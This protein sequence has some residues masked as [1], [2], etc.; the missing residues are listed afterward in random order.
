VCH[1]RLRH[2]SRDFLRRR[3]RRATVAA[4]RGSGWQRDGMGKGTGG[5]DRDVKIRIEHVLRDPRERRLSRPRERRLSR[6][7]WRRTHRTPARQCSAALLGVLGPCVRACCV[8]ACCVQGLCA[9]SGMQRGSN[10]V[11]GRVW[12]GGLQL[13]S[14]NPIAMSCLTTAASLSAS[15]CTDQWPP[16]SNETLVRFTAI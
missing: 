8:C 12:Q 7:C 4:V 16:A 2:K 3:R 15:P 13:F 1:A 10:G 11:R 6:Q 9:G 5:I 14:E